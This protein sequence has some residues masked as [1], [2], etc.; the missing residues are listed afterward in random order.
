M[1]DEHEQTPPSQDDQGEAR[2]GFFAVL[3][4]VIAS[5]LGVQ[6]RQNMERDMRSSSP[7]PYIVVGLLGTIAFIA[8]LIIVVRLVLKSAGA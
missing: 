8:T 2:P 5:G 4:S 3:K 7:L 6:S 1:T